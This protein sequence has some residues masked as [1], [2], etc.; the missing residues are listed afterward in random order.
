MVNIL[1]I[2][3][4]ISIVI[5]MLNSF[6]NSY[7]LKKEEQFLHILNKN[8]SLSCFENDHYK[9]YVI[10]YRN[11]KG[12]IEKYPVFANSKEAAMIL[13]LEETNESYLR[14]LNVT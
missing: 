12:N 2:L 1:A 11:K 7:N 4:L 3:L 5:I 13:F 10:C 14:I 9:E 6:L 8:I